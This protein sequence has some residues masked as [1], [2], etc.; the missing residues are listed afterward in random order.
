MSPL[1]PPTLPLSFPS[2]PLVPILTPD[3]PITSSLPSTTPPH[4]PISLNSPPDS[5][6]DIS[7][8]DSPDHVHGSPPHAATSQPPPS[9][10]PPP[11]ATFQPPPNQDPPSTDSSSSSPIAPPSGT[12]HMVTRSR[13]GIFKPKVFHISV[14][15]PSSTVPRSIPLALSIPIWKA[16]MT[17]E[18]L[19]LLRNKTWTLTLLPPGKNLIGCTWIFRIKKHV[20]GS[21]ARHKARLVAQGFSQEAGFDF[22]DTFSPVVKPNTIRL[23]LSIAVSSG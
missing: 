6:M 4:S 9:Q 12:H 10:A 5:H 22:T 2:L 19:A 3:S 1:I 8:H 14:I 15:D 17:A 18:F 20:S 21:I 16:A 7:P 23:I 13:A 11:A